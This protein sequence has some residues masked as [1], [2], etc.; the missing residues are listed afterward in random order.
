MPRLSNAKLADLAREYLD[1]KGKADGIGA[2]LLAELTRRGKSSEEVDGVRIVAAGSV[3]T[4]YDAAKTR[5]ALG[6]RARK[7]LVS[8][9]DGRKLRSALSA[10]EITQAEFDACIGA[11]KPRQAHPVVTE[12]APAKVAA[13]KP[14]A[15][16]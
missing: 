2:Q 4:E 3:R 16:V 8:K 14:A 6:G 10:G 12:V 15:K 13:A 1:A 7:F 5:A 9:V 11:T